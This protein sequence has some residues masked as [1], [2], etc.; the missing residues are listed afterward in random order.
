ML[1]LM[2]DWPLLCHRLIDHAALN[3]GKRLVVSRTVE[4]PLHTT[5]YAAV[6]ACALQVAKRL[7]RGEHPSGRPGGNACLEH[8]AAS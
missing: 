6:R 4:G 1:G 8:L 5:N 7:E 3:H 2:Q